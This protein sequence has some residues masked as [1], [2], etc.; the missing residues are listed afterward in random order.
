MI[1]LRECDVP[2]I[3]APGSAGPDIAKCLE[4]EVERSSLEGTLSEYYENNVLDILT[5]W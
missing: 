3:T 4:G 2:E 5:T 1:T